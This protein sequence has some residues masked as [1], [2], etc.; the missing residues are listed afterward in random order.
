MK[1]HWKERFPT[2]AYLYTEIIVLICFLF[3]IFYFVFL[4]YVSMWVSEYR[5]YTYMCHDYLPPADEQNHENFKFLI[6]SSSS[7]AS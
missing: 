1:I 3:L 5:K 2:F 4:L 6:F 7:S